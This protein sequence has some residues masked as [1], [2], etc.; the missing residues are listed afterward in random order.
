MEQ[1]RKEIEEWGKSVGAAL[2][3]VAA[4]T[5]VRDYLAHYCARPAMWDSQID[6]TFDGAGKA[7]ASRKAKVQ[8]QFSLA[9]R[10]LGKFTESEIWNM[11]L[12]KAI[13]WHACYL[14]DSPESPLM[15]DEAIALRDMAENES[16]ES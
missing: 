8:W 3:I 10:L 7:R 11:P 4:E 12:C 13:T 9:H 1:S 14:D 5:V 15:E 6:S 2:D 16:T